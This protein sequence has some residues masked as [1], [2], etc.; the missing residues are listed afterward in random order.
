M[1]DRQ[2]SVPILKAQTLLAINRHRSGKLS[3]RFKLRGAQSSDLGNHIS[4][5]RVFKLAQEMEN[6]WS[7]QEVL[8]DS[9]PALAVVSFWHPGI[10]LANPLCV[11]SVNWFARSQDGEIGVDEHL[12]VSICTGIMRLRFP[13]EGSN[14]RAFWN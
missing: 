4:A 9:P 2:A 5:S 11:V 14:Q 1:V 13:N 10:L 12:G 7:A 8:Q 6:L 3:C